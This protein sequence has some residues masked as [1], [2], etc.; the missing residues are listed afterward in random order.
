MLNLFIAFES[1]VDGFYDENAG[2]VFRFWVLFVRK[3]GFD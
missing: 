1:C 3:V 2:S